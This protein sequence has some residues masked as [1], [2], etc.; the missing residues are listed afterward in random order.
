MRPVRIACQ[1]HDLDA[2]V[3]GSIRLEIATTSEDVWNETDIARLVTNQHVWISRTGACTIAFS[4]LV[5]GECV[6][7]K[8]LVA[9]IIA[10]ILTC[11][12]SI[13]I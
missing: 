10:T 1:K 3:E 7:G 8:D 2:R 9:K 5:D 11:T 13:S 4:V 12:V 6:C